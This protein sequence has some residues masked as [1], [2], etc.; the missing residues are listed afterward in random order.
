MRRSKGALG[1]RAR[2]K[3]RRTAPDLHQ[4][5]LVD[6]KGYRSNPRIELVRGSGSYFL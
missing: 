4:A 5:H 2:A 3:R 1:A 6:Y